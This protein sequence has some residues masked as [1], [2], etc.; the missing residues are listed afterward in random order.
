MENFNE[1]LIKII[2]ALRRFTEKMDNP[3]VNQ[4]ISPFLEKA[5]VGSIELG[6]ISSDDRLT[7]VFILNY[8]DNS[9]V[10]LATGNFWQGREEDY[11][12]VYVLEE[13]SLVRVEQSGNFEK[14]DQ[15]KWEDLYSYLRITTSNLHMIEKLNKKSDEEVEEITTPNLNLSDATTKIF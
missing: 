9:R 11:T 15:K 7:N 8:A 1:I 2:I 10:V 4:L 13:N 12:I 5:N 14:H 3:Q 6:N